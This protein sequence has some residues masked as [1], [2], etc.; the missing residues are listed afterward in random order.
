MVTA[1]A[2]VVAVAQVWSLAQELPCAVGTAKKEKKNQN[3]EG[4]IRVRKIIPL[5]KA[6]N[7]TFV[8]IYI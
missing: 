3:Y 6:Y 7:E 2:R 5:H 1:A 8:P 4:K